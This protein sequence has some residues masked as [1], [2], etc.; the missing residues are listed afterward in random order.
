MDYDLVQNVYVSIYSP[1]PPPGVPSVTSLPSVTSDTACG[2]SS[3]LLSILP[4]NHVLTQE[5]KNEI[6]CSNIEKL[7][8]ELLEM[9]VPGGQ[10]QGA[11]LFAGSCAHNLTPEAMADAVKRYR[12]VT[13]SEPHLLVNPSSRQLSKVAK[14]R[15][16][17]L[18]TMAEFC[19]LCGSHM[20]AH[21][22]LPQ[23][24]DS[25]DSNLPTPTLLLFLLPLLPILL[26][27]LLP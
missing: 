2:P 10:S 25:L 17:L 20:L 12:M 1:P 18:G 8:L 14:C 7:T 11:Y 27:I 4:G 23:G 6:V 13:R 9:L 21:D 5:E 15:D 19:L 26:P 3:A 24:S 22:L 16:V